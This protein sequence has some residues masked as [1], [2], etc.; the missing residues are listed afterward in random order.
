MAANIMT[1]GNLTEPEE[2]QGPSADCS[3]IFSRTAGEDVYC[4]YIMFSDIDE[5]AENPFLC[6]E[7]TTCVNLPGGHECQCLEGYQGNVTGGENCTGT[8][9]CQSSGTM[10]SNDS[11]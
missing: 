11:I 4:V 10:L 7:N 6:G 9:N 5:C 3:K 1:G 8:E 2:H